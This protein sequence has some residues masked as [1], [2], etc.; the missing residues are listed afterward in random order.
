ML[1]FVVV[2]W[3]VTLSTTL[4]SISIVKTFVKTW[5]LSTWNILFDRRFLEVEHWKCSQQVWLSS[6]LTRT[7]RLLLLCTFF[8]FFATSTLMLALRGNSW[9]LKVVTVGDLSLVVNPLG[10]PRYVYYAIKV[11]YLTS[12]ECSVKHFVTLFWKVLNK[13]I[14]TR[15]NRRH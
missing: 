5:I 13:S 1:F 15:F 2:E 7:L 14:S 8:S 9:L 3:K 4:E 11:G 12:P 6:S 10:S